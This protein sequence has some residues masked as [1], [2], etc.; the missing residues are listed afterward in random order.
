[1]KSRL[2]W[3]LV[4]VGCLSAPLLAQDAASITGTVTDQTGAAIPNAQVTVNNP[5]HGINRTTTSNGSGDYL[6]SALPPGSYNLS[7]TAAGFKK[8]EAKGV[9]LRVAQKARADAALQVGAAKEEVLVEGTNVAQVET[10]SNELAGTITSKEISQLQLNGRVFTQLVT[11]TPGITNQ[12]GS[13]EG[14]YGITANVNYSVNG[15]RLEYNNW[16]LDGGDNMDNGSNSTLNVTPSIDAIGEVRVLTS[17]YGAQYGRNGSGTIE[18]E[19]KSGTRSFHGDAYEFVRNEAFNATPEFQTTNPAYHKNDWGYTIGGPIYIPGHYNKDKQKTFF[20]WSQEWRRDRVPGQNFN[21][22][23]PSLAERGGNFSDLCPGLDCPV[24]PTEINGV[25]NPLAGQPFPG[26]QVPVNPASAPLLGMIPSPTG[27]SGNVFTAAPSQATNWREELVRVDHNFSDKIRAM[28]RYAHDS[29]ET[30]TATPLWSDGASFPTI[31]TNFVG[32]ATA[33]VARLT[34]TA[35]PTLLN[36]FV[37]SYT[38]DHI[39]LTN[40]GTPNPN[41]WK[42]PANLAISSL[43]PGGNG[44]LPGISVAGGLG[45]AYGSSGFQE[46][47][48]FV[49]NGPYNANPTYTY[50]DN[51]TKIIGKHNLQFGAYFVAAQKNELTGTVPSTNGFLTFDPTSPVSSGN[52]FADLLMGN[53]ANFSQSNAQPKY[54]NRY[55][56][57]E[58]YFQDDFH[59]T[60]RLTLNMGLRLSLFGTY[61]ERYHQ[62]YNFEPSAWVAAKAPEIDVTGNLTGQQG[63]IV[64]GTGDPFNGMVQCGVNGSPAGCMKGH[65]FNPAPRLGFAFDPKGD[66][67]WAIRGGYGIFFDHTNGNEADSEALESSPPLVQVPTQYNIS[68]YGN[69]GGGGNSSLLFPLNVVS[70]PTKAVWPY[71]QQ[72]HLDVQHDVGWSTVA[73]LSYV[74]SKGTDLGRKYELNQ[75]HPVPAALNPYVKA[76]QPIDAIDPATGQPHDDCGTMTTESGLPVTGQAAINLS[77]ACGNDPNPFR[78]FRGLGDITALDNKASSSYNALQAQ[79]RRSIG[80][81]QLNVSYTYSH[82]ID[83]ASD[84]GLFGDGGILNAYDFAAFRASSNFDQRHTFTTSAIYD[85]P[86]FKSPGITNK[87]LGGW[88]LSGIGTWQTGTPFS[89]YNGSGFPDNAGLG[90]GVA[91][92]A[93]AGQ[94][95]ADVISNPYQNIPQVNPAANV[96]A[97]GFGSFIANPNAF[98]APIGLTLGDSGRNFLRNPGHWNIDMAL[99]KHIPIRESM[100]F[101]FRAEAFNIFNHVEYGPLAGDQGGAAGSAGFSSGTGTFIPGP[102]SNF[103]QVGTVYSPRILQLGAKFLF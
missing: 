91:S 87:L 40:T 1:M 19:T 71:V 59:A 28:F 21:V 5:E 65:L 75:L 79:L 93:G 26:N 82:S 86:F 2:L 43:F 83:S 100:A 102:G 36:E 13:S 64:P 80:T 57:L 15:G 31:Q 20:F 70:I 67:K 89:A 17:N 6:V 95:Y 84:G 77:V 101:E 90:N 53:I 69:I 88:E 10:Q 72:W 68:G 35:S 30:V 99:F 60:R 51:V 61:R 50:R 14:Q 92:S 62:A 54:Y 73:T 25:K 24:Q 81:M 42:R 39:V 9:V 58:P 16:E 23:V 52:P 74:G 103:L 8:Y 78:P 44:A 29:W 41:A 37:F 3:V 66:G 34:A 45:G 46:D 12:T 98:A 4:F 63:A 18:T 48:G 76:N 11:L 7:I 27:G 97:S 32:P 38:T 33:L 56:I 94:S 47:A 49:P 85:L 55:K 96:G 22:I